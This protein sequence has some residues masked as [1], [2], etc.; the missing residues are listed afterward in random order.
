MMID[1]V[2]SELCAGNLVDS[3]WMCVNPSCKDDVRYTMVSSPG[4]VSGGPN[5]KRAGMVPA[6][7]QSARAT[8]VLEA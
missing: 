6:R 5:P 8:T 1:S 3:S 4:R 2:Q 7:R